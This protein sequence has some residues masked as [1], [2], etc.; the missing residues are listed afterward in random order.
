[1]LHFFNFS[2][3]VQLSLGLNKTPFHSRCIDL[4]CSRSE[5][6]EEEEEEVMKKD[7]ECNS[8]GGMIVMKRNSQSV[9]FCSHWTQ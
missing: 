5:E 2:Q 4:G 6:E 7:I 3:D 9:I 1:M 8:G